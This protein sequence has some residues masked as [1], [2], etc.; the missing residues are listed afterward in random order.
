MQPVGKLDQD[1]TDVLR[2]RQ[3]HLAQ[4]LGLL[5]LDGPRTE[6]GQLGDAVDEPGHLR[7]EAL[8][9]VVE[10][11]VGV[12]RDVVQQGCL[13]GNRVKTELGQRACHGQR[14]ADVRL[15]ACSALLSVC[16][17]REFVGRAHG[18]DVRLRVV[19]QQLFLE[20]PLG[21]VE[22]AP[23]ERR[24]NRAGDALAWTALG[25]SRVGGGRRRRCLRRGNRLDR[26]LISVYASIPRALGTQTAH[27][28]WPARGAV[29]LT[30]GG[31]LP[32]CA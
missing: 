24:L 28:G 1:D 6:L 20:L 16:L 18:R 30:D 10:R 2:H 19:T 31:R 11:V 3:E 8:L 9:D 22:G 26:H 25:R 23:G 14:V 15:A 5:L 27:A 17:D 7:P 4:A 12:L 32:L 21:S 29:V 13:D